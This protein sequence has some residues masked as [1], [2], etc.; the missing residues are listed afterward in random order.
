MVTQ[1]YRTTEAGLIAPFEYVGMPMA[2]F[3]G[4]MVFGTFPDATAWVGHCAD[5]RR[6]AFM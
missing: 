2:I 3:W 5:L 4:L 6:P 1:A